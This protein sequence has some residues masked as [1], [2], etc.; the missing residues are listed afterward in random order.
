MIDVDIL[1]TKL[2]E[3]SSAT[4][5]TPQ[6]RGPEGPLNHLRKEINEA[7]DDPDDIVEFADMYMLLSDAAS[8][9]GHSMSDVLYASIEKLLV[10]KKREWGPINADGFSEHVRDHDGQK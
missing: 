3:W 5:G 8:R 4:F 9:A 10:N 6:E 1:Q 2:F 7:I